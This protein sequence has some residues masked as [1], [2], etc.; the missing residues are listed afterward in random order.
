MM[1]DTVPLAGVIEGE[2]DDLVLLHPVGLDGSFWGELPR[3]LQKG[4]RILR[5]DLRGHGRS[6]IG[7]S[8]PPIATYAADVAAAIQ[9][10]GMQR[11]AVLGLSFG[12]MIAQMLALDHP[13][14]VSR[15]VLS[16]CPGGIPENVGPVLRERGLAAERDGMASIVPATVERW[17]T[18]GFVQ[19]PIVE[20][21]R[22]RLREDDVRGWSD[23]W[24]AIAGFDALPRNS[25]I[26]VPT[27]VVSG[28]LDAATSP[29]ASTALAASIPGAELVT[30]PGAPHMMQLETSKLFA[31]AVGRFLARNPAA[32]V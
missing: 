1:V 3:A 31:D 2:G 6:A 15:L 28:A 18:P 27:L 10:F 26:S 7:V 32:R 4:R 20:R 24:H 29:A 17:F 19:S 30:L 11:P 5:L 21:V 25:E 22:Q 9:S 16:G 8:R 12:G 13:D 23:G 14:L